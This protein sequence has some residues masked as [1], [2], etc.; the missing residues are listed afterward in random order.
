M[1]CSR[2]QHNLL[3]RPHLHHLSLL[4]LLHIPRRELQPRGAQVLVKDHALHLVPC[5]D[6]EVGTLNNALVVARSGV[7]AAVG[8][9][10]EGRGEPE[11]AVFAAGAV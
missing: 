5:D 4:P 1:H 10:V 8:L 2:R 6:V 7:R 9:G 3:P 11:E